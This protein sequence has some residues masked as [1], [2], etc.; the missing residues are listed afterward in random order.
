LCLFIAALPVFCGRAERA[1]LV[2]AIEVVVND[3]VITI[4][5]IEDDVMA[6]AAT[7]AKRYAGNEPLYVKEMEKLR[8]E[9][10]E[11][12]VE[13]KLALHEF[14]TGGY[15]T[16]MIESFIDDQIQLII[17]R[18]YAGDRARFITTLHAQGKTYESFRRKFRENIIIHLMNDQNASSARK[19]LISPLKVAKYY[20]TH[21]SEF[22]VEDQVHLFMIDIPQS[23]DDPPDTAKRRMEEILA[24]IDSGVPFSEMAAVYSAGSHRSQGG[25]RGWV[26]R[27][28]L[29]PALSEVAFSLKPGKHSGVIAFRDACYLMEVDEVRLAHTKEM[30]EVSTDIEHTLL[31]NERKRLHELWIQRLKRKSFIEYYP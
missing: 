19:I 21:P 29:D 3:S 15:V 26:G 13:D 25:D 10:T 22:K 30:K 9:A 2:T 20:E 1:D 4:G 31:D 14:A 18:E 28:F 17:R 24:K 6:S 23:P 27:T 11:Q 12:E 16:N 5:D 7:I 8:Q